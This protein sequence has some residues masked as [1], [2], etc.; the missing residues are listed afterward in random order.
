MSKIAKLVAVI[1][2]VFSIMSIFSACS[3][4]NKQT[5]DEQIKAAYIAEHPRDHLANKDITLRYYGEFE[6]TYVLMIYLAEYGY[7]DAVYHD[8][9]SDVRFIYPN[10]NKLK[11]YSN[12]EFYSLKEAYEK[13]LLTHDNLLETQKNYRADH[14]PLYQNHSET[15]NPQDNTYRLTVQDTNGYVSEKLQEYYKA[16]EK[17][18]VKSDK[19]VKPH[20]YLDGVELVDW[21]LIGTHWEFYF[22]MPEHDAVLSFK[23]GEEGIPT[24]DLDEAIRQEIIE[25]YIRLNPY[26]ALYPDYSEGNIHITPYGIFDNTY[27]V[28]IRYGNT[29]NNSFHIETI[30]GINF[31]F[32][33]GYTFSV[34]RDGEICSL[35]DAFYRGWLT[36]RNLEAVQSKHREGREALYDA[37]E[38]KQ[39]DYV[40]TIS[41][42]KQVY[43]L[44]EDIFIDIT[45][46]NRSGKDM[47]IAY[48]FLFYTESNTGET[49]AVHELPMV[50]TKKLFKNGEIIQQTRHSDISFP[51]GHHGLKYKAIF[52][53]S[54]EMTEYGYEETYD[55][56][57]V[58]SNEIEFTVEE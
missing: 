26:I 2:F 34:Y 21:K 32:E 37:Y 53:L 42:Q 52:Y 46:E 27:V 12:G 23:A 35:H 51:T 50:T 38:N 18:T 44:Y 4:K 29:L 20:V 17:V 33:A 48:Y 39:Q 9:V 19:D 30:Y 15:N 36:P 24:D 57:E 45:L 13:G 1:L 54:W 6:G 41:A 11:V 43:G 47:E 25:A 14:E 40:L 31:Y 10:S 55:S 16:G 22:D 49:Y 3:D 5:I 8:I 7:F 28:V 56:V 58:W